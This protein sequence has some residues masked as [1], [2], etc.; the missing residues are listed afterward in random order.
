MNVKNRMTESGLDNEHAK[1]GGI[2]ISTPPP[3]NTN[4]DFS[5]AAYS[6]PSKFS[7]RMIESAMNN[8]HVKRKRW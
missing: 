1:R 5:K 4:K 6:P 7:N 8:E 3:K 2:N